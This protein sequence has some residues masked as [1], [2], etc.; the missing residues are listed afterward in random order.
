MGQVMSTLPFDEET[1]AALGL[2]IMA[3]L[4]ITRNVRALTLHWHVDH[5]PTLTVEEY[6]SKP[7]ADGADAAVAHLSHFVLVERAEPAATQEASHAG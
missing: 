2:A 4:G 6:M 5:L 1:N 3:A 7:A